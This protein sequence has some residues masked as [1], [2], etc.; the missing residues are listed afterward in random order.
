VGSFVG[1]AVGV[2]V[3]DLESDGDELENKLGFKV[4]FREGTKLTEGQNDSFNGVD[5][6]ELVVFNCISVGLG[7]NESGVGISDGI[8]IASGEVD[9]ELPVGA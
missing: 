2:K 7:E 5:G 3:G 9:E 6:R 4:A 1:A 8:L